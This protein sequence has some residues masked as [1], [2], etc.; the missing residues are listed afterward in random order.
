MPPPFGG[1]PS[2]LGATQPQVQVP[3][4]LHCQVSRGPIR[5][6]GPNVI[7]HLAIPGF[8]PANRLGKGVH[9]V[10]RHDHCYKNKPHKEMS[11][12]SNQVL[13]E[14]IIIEFK[15]Y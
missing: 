9:Q 3:A 8:P 13:P 10:N 15:N 4:G 1:L 6:W 7:L 2:G 12:Q 5:G 11:K 14:Y